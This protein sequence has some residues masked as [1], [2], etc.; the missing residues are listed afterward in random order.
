[1][2]VRNDLLKRI[3]KKLIVIFFSIN[4][5]YYINILLYNFCYILKNVLSEMIR[6]ALGLQTPGIYQW[7]FL[8]T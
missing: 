3:G 8:I 6:N 7:V 5:N 4:N 1:M 2:N